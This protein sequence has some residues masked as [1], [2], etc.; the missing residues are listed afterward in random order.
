MGGGGGQS[1]LPEQ[2]KS[3]AARALVEHCVAELGRPEPVQN[4]SEE[5]S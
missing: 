2:P 1:A 4:V 3:D 5:E